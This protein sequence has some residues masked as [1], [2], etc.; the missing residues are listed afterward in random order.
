MKM[1]GIDDRMLYF[2]HTQCPCSKC[3]NGFNFALGSCKAFPEGIPIEILKGEN[4]HSV[5]LDEQEND[6]VFKVKPG[7]ELYS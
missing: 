2:R 4:K 5:P 3:D 7:F 1:E 6:I